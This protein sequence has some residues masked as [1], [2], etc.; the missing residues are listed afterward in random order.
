M[1]W[2]GAGEAY[3]ASYASLCAGTGARMREL[4][5]AADGTLLDVGA[6]DGTLAAAWADAELLRVS[7]GTVIATTAALA[8]HR[9]R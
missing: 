7:R 9:I 1:S 5:G 2:Q 3:A 8:V 6:G 4:A